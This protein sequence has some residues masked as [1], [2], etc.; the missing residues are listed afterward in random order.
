MV[1][2]SSTDL[3]A[4]MDMDS[5]RIFQLI[6]TVVPFE[7]CLYYQVLPISLEGNI[8]KL[9]VVDGQDDSALDYVQR[10]LAYMN[11]SVTTEQISSETQRSM[12]SAYL[13]HGNQVKEPSPT[14]TAAAPAPK[15]PAPANSASEAKTPTSFSQ[16]SIPASRLKATTAAIKPASAEVYPTP[17]DVPVL[18]V[19]A[20]YLSSPV[21]VLANLPAPQLLEE[22]L[23]RV[24]LDG[25]GRLFFERPQSQGR[26]LWSQDGVLKSVLEGIEP[27]LFEEVIDEL[28]RLTDMPVSPVEQ[29]KQVEVERIYKNTHL[30]LRLRVMTVGG[31]EEATLQV[32]RGAALRF[33][34]QQQL[35]SLSRDALRLAKELQRKVNL[36]RDRTRLSPLPLDGLPALEQVV[37]NVDD[38]LEALMH[39]HNPDRP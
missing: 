9:G 38:Q 7:A 30:L 18:D 2:T 20:S 5:D 26:I 33:Y 31:K 6:D 37:K 16:P 1:H 22:L 39:E 19:E 32:L 12:L 15:N 25:I 24:L 27:V 14:P 10:I 36:M 23:G 29:P 35:S 21:E 3:A 17:A 34:Q 4:T 11:C 28:K 8:L 13:L